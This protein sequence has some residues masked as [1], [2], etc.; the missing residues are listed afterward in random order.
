MAEGAVP[1][2]GL[3]VSQEASELAVQERGTLSL[4]EILTILF[5]GLGSVAIPLRLNCDGLTLKTGTTVSVTGTLSGE[6]DAPV[7][8]I[9]IVPL[10]V[11][12]GKPVTSIETVA[13]EGVVPL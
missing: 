3:K 4:L 13:F 11:P 7:E 6:L 12:S 1:L 2:V 5:C 9:V 8:P 10:Y